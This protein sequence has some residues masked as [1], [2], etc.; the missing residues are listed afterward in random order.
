MM[1][2]DMQMPVYMLSDI[3]CSWRQLTMTLSERVSRVV[4]FKMGLG[5]V[6]W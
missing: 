1:S 6:C 4:K 2:V 3:K 5:F